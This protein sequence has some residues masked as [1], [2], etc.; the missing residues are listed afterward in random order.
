MNACDGRRSGEGVYLMPSR[1]PG[2]TTK[3]IVSGCAVY[4]VET[5]VLDFDLKISYSASEKVASLTYMAEPV[6]LA[7]KRSPSTDV[8]S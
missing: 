4:F 5:E 2:N 6:G 3:R 7:I 8:L 1:I